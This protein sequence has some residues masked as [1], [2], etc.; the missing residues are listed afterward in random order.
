MLRRS[1]NVG[2]FPGHFVFPGGHAEVTNL[3]ISRYYL[4][5]GQFIFYVNTMINSGPV[6]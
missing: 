4:L 2:E 5:Y 6:E 3:E 1:N